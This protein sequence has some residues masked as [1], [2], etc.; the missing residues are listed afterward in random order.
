MK[1]S[2]MAESSATIQLF[3]EGISW[4]KTLSDKEG[5]FEFLNVPLEEGI[6]TF[7]AT[8]TDTGGNVSQMSLPVTVTFLKNPPQVEL[9]EPSDGTKITGEDKS[10]KVSGKT[11]LVVS[12]TINDR[13]IILAN[14]GSFTF[15][16]PLS[17]GDNKMTIV[18]TD[19]AGNKTTVERTVNYSP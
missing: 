5:R 16:F 9:T 1:V 19:I 15:Q 12:L 7:R 2:G 3:A 10:V 18:G 8:A 14:D 17:E 4:G 11:E 13:V 6:N